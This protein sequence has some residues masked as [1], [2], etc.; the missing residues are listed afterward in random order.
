MM[1]P[2]GILVLRK[3]GFVDGRTNEVPANDIEW[4][5]DKVYEGV[6]R[7]PLFD[8]EEEYYEGNRT[9]DF[10]RLWDD[11]QAKMCSH[12]DWR[13]FR[14]IE[15]AKKV[16]GFS[17]KWLDKNELVVI[18][19]ESLVSSCGTLSNCNRV[20][21]LGVDVYVHGYG[22]IIKG[23]VFRRPKLF[24]WPA[25]SKINRHGLFCCPDDASRYLHA[26]R[27]V[28]ERAGLE[29]IADVE[30]LTEL[31]WVGKLIGGAGSSL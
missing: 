22:S 1:S 2:S 9:E 12:W 5:R 7:M 26:Y 25:K 27:D 23:G 6:E 14:E 31:V 16:I 15:V 11:A 18:T 17:G 30:E 20:A 28:Q 8:F 4:M 21:W 19:S 10:M 13:V 29:P 3:P 24:E